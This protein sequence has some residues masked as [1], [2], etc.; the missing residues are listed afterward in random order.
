MQELAVQ[1]GGGA[2]LVHIRPWVWFQ[3][4]KQEEEEKGGGG[5]FGKKMRKEENG[6]EE[7][8]TN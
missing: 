8:E 7:E 4:N 5:R 3:A 2:C 1:F 6:E